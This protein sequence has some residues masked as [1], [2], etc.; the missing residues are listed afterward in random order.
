[1]C[2]HTAT[3]R[4]TSMEGVSARGVAQ[5]S[6]GIGCEGFGLLEMRSDCS[7]VRPTVAGSRSEFTEVTGDPSEVPDQRQR[8]FGRR[9][10]RQSC[11]VGQRRRCLFNR[12]INWVVHEHAAM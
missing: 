8:L 6:C 10:H 1:M 7:P 5:A 2:Q 4:R 11:R 3:N 9:R 12:S